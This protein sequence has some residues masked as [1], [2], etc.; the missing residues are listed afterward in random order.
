MKVLFLDPSRAGQG[1]LPLNIPLLIAVL[2]KHKHDVRVFNIM[3]YEAFDNHSYDDMFFKEA[4]FDTGRITR[5]RNNFY[6]H[7][8]NSNTVDCGLKK[9]DYC[10]DYEKLLNSFM[11]NI[12]A[13]S[14]MSKD[15]RFV[16]EFLGKFKKKYKIPV[17][18]GGI[19]AILLPEET[20]NLAVCDFVC[21]GE[22]ENTFVALLESMENDKPLE[23]VKG[24][25]FKKK[26]KIIKNAPAHLSDLTKASIPDYE[27]FDPIH[28]YRPFNGKRYKM[29]N[30][31]LSRGCLFDCTYC[32]NGVL[33][34]KYKGLGRYHRIKDLEQSIKELK[35][36]V[37]RYNFDFV[38]FWDEDFTSIKSKYINEYANLYRK[39]INLPFLIYARVDTVTEKK[40]QILKEMG[41]RTFA[42]GI[43]SG[44]EFIRKHVMNR[45]MSNKTII[46]KFSLVK[47]YGI[48]VSAYNIIGLP[49]ETR[50]Y[51]FDTIELN[52][53]INPDSL[54]VTLLE[55]YKAVPIRK[56]C[57]EQGLDPDHEATYNEPQ[58]IPRG[59]TPEELSGL[60]RTFAFYVQFPKERY[61]EIKAAETD[62]EIYQKLNEEYINKL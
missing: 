51:I 50:E 48:R 12:I 37:N 56:M 25:W 20:V 33:K 11:P 38:R 34:E 30:Y 62:D 23:D 4:P 21:T 47:S 43:E 32:V 31:E 8:F 52:R 13:V 7:E 55:P 46:E 17:I 42:M 35:F 40:V 29:L 44:N 9:S 28:F 15:F 61:S 36:L 58:F 22:G 1:N 16:C 60:F 54:S 53:D 59:M 2:K 27:C 10:R 5:D 3:D 24:I 39:E 19:H 18:F 57:E 26:G 6:K 49:F 14:C 45:K 41:C